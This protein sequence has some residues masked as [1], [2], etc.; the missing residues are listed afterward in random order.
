MITIRTKHKTGLTFEIPSF[1][2]EGLDELF[3]AAHKKYDGNVVL[4]ISLPHRPRTTKEDSQNHKIRGDCKAISDQF[5][6][7]D[8]QFTPGFVH[9][10]LKAFAVKVKVYPFI[11]VGEE[12]IPISE[13][14]LS[15]EEASRFIEYIEL[16]SDENNLWLIRKDK[17]GTYRSVGGRTR[18]EMEQYK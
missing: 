13:A 11:K 8:P 14:D 7:H 3:A 12:I 9:A 10:M 4:K 6:E 16:F 18:E 15:V 1:L 2:I 17:K 5:I